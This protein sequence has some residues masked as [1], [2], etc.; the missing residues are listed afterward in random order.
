MASARRP[1]TFSRPAATK[2]AE[3]GGVTTDREDDGGGDR[4][5]Q[6]KRKL[7][8][9]LGPPWS[10]DELNLFYQGYRK[11]G[12]YWKKVAAN[13]HKRTVEMV[14]ALYNT[15]KAYLSLPEGAASVAGLIAMMTDHYNLLDDSQ[16]Q[17]EDTSDEHEI[18]DE[19]PYPTQLWRGRTGAGNI[20]L[21]TSSTQSNGPVGTSVFSGSSPARKPRTNRSRTVGKR[22]SR[23]PVES[24]V[25]MKMRHHV[26]PTNFPLQDEEELE[27]H[28]AAAHT[29]VSRRTASPSVCNTPS[30]RSLRQVMAQQNGDSK[31]HHGFCLLLGMRLHIFVS[32][33]EIVKNVL[34]RKI[35]SLFYA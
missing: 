25:E 27:S 29:L 5:K 13:M 1:R 18:S 19:P 4:Y 26:S 8:D 14:E 10:E 7:A 3:G 2:G 32:K 30:R 17:N 33:L 34:V 6:R 31:V 35:D 22:T 24:I 15:N 12:K 11:H 28:V 21:E 9:M 23:F 20:G 16:S